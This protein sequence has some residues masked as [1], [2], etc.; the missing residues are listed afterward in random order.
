MYDTRGARLADMVFPVNSVSMLGL[1]RMFKAFVYV[2]R[3]LQ[4]GGEESQKHGDFPQLVLLGQSVFQVDCS[5][6]Q[7]V[8]FFIVLY[9]DADELA[10]RDREILEKDVPYVCVGYCNRN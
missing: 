8:V 6:I 2:D 7:H 9:S 4:K 1:T 3:E 10:F 5:D